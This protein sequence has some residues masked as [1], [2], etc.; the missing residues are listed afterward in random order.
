MLRL[1]TLFR[2]VPLC[3]GVLALG[4]AQPAAAD[5]IYSYTGNSFGY[6]GGPG[7]VTNVSGFFDLSETLAASTTYDLTP[8]TNASVVNY[9]FT[10]GNTVFDLANNNASPTFPVLGP[11]T[12]SVTTDANGNIVNWDLN[13]YTGTSEIQTCNGTC[14]GMFA[15]PNPSD[16]VNVYETYV[17]YGVSAAGTWSETNIPEPASAAI[18]LMALLGSRALRRRSPAQA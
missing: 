15:G 9:S 17:A 13:I 10:D 8:S 3:A 11:E 16:S 12:F 7:N 18:V 2:M 14:S 5:I 4:V 6:D 1:K